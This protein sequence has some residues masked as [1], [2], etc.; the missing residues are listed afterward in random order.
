MTR[1]SLLAA[2]LC[3]AHASAEPAT[4]R[5]LATSQAAPMT[6]HVRATSVEHNVFVL[7]ADPAYSDTRYQ[8]F[9]KTSA[10]PPATDEHA[11]LTLDVETDRAF[12]LFDAGDRCEIIH[13]A[14]DRD[15]LEK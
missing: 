12:L 10:C 14:R 13:A 7:N 11:L 9:V 3:A 5:V 1:H 4:F 8:V 2:I 15:G 6:T